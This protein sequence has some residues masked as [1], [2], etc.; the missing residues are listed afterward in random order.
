M[1]C[2]DKNVA[3]CKCCDYNIS[4]LQLDSEF[5]VSKTLT[6][7]LTQYPMTLAKDSNNTEE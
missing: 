1:T 5:P 2:A 6:H 7:D 3:K 4:Y